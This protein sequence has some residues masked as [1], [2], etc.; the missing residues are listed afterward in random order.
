MSTDATILDVDFQDDGMGRITVTAAL[1]DDSTSK[2]FSY[3]SDEHSFTTASFVGKTLAE[4]HS[5]FHGADV[6]YLQS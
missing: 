3:F 6:D 4:A 2:L 5:M 1:S